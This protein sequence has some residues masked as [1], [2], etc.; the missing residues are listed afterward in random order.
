VHGSELGA[1]E[2]AVDRGRERLNVN[3]EVRLLGKLSDLPAYVRAH[4]I[5]VIFIALLVRHVRRAM[6]LVDELRDTTASI[7]YLP[8]IFVFDLIQARSGAIDGIRLILK[9]EPPFWGYRAIAKRRTDILISA[10]IFLLI[11]PLLVAVPV[12]LSSQGPA[13]F[14]QR[15]Y[16]RDEPPQLI[17]VLQGRISRVGPSPRAVAHNEMYR[18]LIKGYMIR[19]KVRPGIIGL[20]Q[21]NGL[22]GETRTLEQMEARVRYDLEYLRNWPIVLDLGI[23]AKIVLRVLNDSQAFYSG[24]GCARPR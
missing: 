6:D 10:A 13:I 20:A 22:R 16:S 11:G 2:L 8:D 4:G 7:C 19:H 21:V 1:G 17:N 15:R 18:K 12:K 3:G 24:L 14:R 9:C 23:L 5:G